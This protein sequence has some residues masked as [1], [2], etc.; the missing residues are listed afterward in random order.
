MWFK[1]N[2]DRS[3]LNL[4]YILTIYEHPHIFLVK[5]DLFFNTKAYFF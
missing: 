5:Y 4:S 2:L 3:C 1:Y